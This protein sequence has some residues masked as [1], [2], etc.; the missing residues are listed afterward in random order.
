MIKI[1]FDGLI[2]SEKKI[3]LDIGCFFEGEDMDRVTRILESC[4]YYP[5]IGIQ[6]L[7]EKVVTVSKGKLWMHD[8][9]QELGPVVASGGYHSCTCK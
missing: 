9:I 6:V 1:S 5:D 7:I 4:G 8:L 3:F 2:E